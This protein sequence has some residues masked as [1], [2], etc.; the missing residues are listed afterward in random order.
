MM[1]YIMQIPEIIITILTVHVGVVTPV[2]M[3][4]ADLAE[5]TDTM[6]DVEL[7]DAAVDLMAV[8]ELAAVVV[9]IADLA[10]AVVQLHSVE[11]A[12]V[13]AMAVV[14]NHIMTSHAKNQENVANMI[15]NMITSLIINHVIHSANRNINQN[16]T[17]PAKNSVTA[18][19]ARDR[20][21]QFIME[22]INK[23]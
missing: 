10:E 12:M 11:D 7:V 2:V 19:I 3:A 14:V 1:K 23:I 16:A 5:V 21:I 22:D 6:V 4:D 20:T 18:K 13:H 9:M 15:T 8:A 17:I